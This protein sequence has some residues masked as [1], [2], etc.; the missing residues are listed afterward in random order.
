MKKYIIAWIITFIFI[1]TSNIYWYN[2]GM[3]YMRFILENKSVCYEG[4]IWHC[5]SNIERCSR[6]TNLH[7]ACIENIGRN[8]NE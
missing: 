4:E 8:T 7:E 3:N 5:W 1:V 2:R 6:A